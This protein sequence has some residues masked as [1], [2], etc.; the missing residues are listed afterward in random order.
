[1]GRIA[2]ESHQFFKEHHR[3]DFY[4]MRMDSS[5]SEAGP[6]TMSIRRPAG[7]EPIMNSCILAE[8]LFDFI[9]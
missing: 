7:W 8:Q 6:A 9:P 5:T 2:L 4:I 3:R 1:M